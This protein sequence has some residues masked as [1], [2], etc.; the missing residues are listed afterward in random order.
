MLVLMDN[1]VSE[2]DILVDWVKECS[3]IGLLELW[4]ELNRKNSN[5]VDLQV[6]EE[7]S[8][9]IQE[10]FLEVYLVHQKV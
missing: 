6:E 8:Q 4:L 2:I 7:F 5:L 9:D 3:H 1:Q 10:F